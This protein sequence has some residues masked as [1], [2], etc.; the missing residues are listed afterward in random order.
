LNQSLS[1]LRR[2]AGFTLV[3]V[4]M[5][6]VIMM[7]GFIGL[8]ESVAVA[9]SSMDHARRQTLATQIINHEIEDLFLASWATI[10]ALPT[11][12]TTITIDSQFHAAMQSVGDYRTTAD[13]V[14]FSLARTVTSPDP[15]TN[16]REVNFTVT[17]VVKTSRRDGS[18]NRVSF[19]HTRANSVWL[20]KYGLHL[21]YPQS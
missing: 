7:V 20:G 2:Q 4:M 8:V 18:G 13:S 19:T 6:A 21:S 3:E 5:A 1:Q 11:G 16:I 12:S 15:V 10:A 14:T 17:W 9:T